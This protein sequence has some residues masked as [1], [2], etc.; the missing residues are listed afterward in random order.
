M[1]GHFFFTFEGF[2]GIIYIL[3]EESIN[4]G[5][6]LQINIIYKDILIR[7]AV[8]ADAAQLASWWN[9]GSVM[10]HA[11]FPN[12]VNTNEERIKGQIKNYTDL[13]RVLMIEYKGKAIGE[14]NY[15]FSDDDRCEIGIKICDSTYQE[16]GL[17]RVILTLFIEELFKMGA[18]TIFLTTNLDNK[19]AQHVYEKLGFKKIRVDYD[20]WTNQLGDLQSTVVYELKEEEL[21]SFK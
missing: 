11:G 9:D 16:K 5:V 14:M 3:Q 7:N 10:A 21:I 20:S 12:G 8:E 4:Q 1:L 18:R 13:H 6:N 2:R 19:R 17:G 15:E